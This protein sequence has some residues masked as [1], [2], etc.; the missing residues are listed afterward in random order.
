MF[1]G[2]YKPIKDVVIGDRLA[3]V[4]NK[5]E[6]VVTSVFRFAGGSTPMVAVG[7]VVMSAQHYVMAGGADMMVPASS[8]PS[9]VSVASIPELVCLNVTGHRFVVG[10]DGLVVADYDEHSDGAVVTAAQRMALG[11]LNSGIVADETDKPIA[12]YSLGVGG[13]TEVCMA[14]GT[15]K[16]VDK[17]AIGDVVKYSG[18]V[19]GVV[20]ETCASVVKSPTGITFSGAQLVYNQTDNRWIRS[21]NR[22]GEA[23]KG[24][25]AASILY[26]IFTKNSGVLL[27]RCAGGSGSMEY[28]RDYRE[29]PL[30]D[31]EDAYTA[32]FVKN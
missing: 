29:V 10:Y 4:S 6:V 13:E 26:S 28:T 15:W 17:V 14:D 8:H 27:V 19:L 32:A 5:D 2:T 9:A 31:M 24:D 1:D 25:G 23:G 12:D 16:R 7:D 21:A 3:G 22:W 30:P 20:A 11:A 18:P